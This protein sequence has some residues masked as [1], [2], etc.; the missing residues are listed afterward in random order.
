MEIGPGGSWAV[1]L[2]LPYY[3]PIEKSQWKLAL[4]AA[5]Q[6]PSDFLIKFLLEING[7]WRWRLLDSSPQSSLLNSY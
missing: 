5:G 4:A 6:F 2:S 7:N 3:I 1:S